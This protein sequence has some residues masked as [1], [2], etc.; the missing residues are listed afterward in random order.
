[1]DVY[2]IA[3]SHF[4]S[5]LM[6]LKVAAFVP[7]KGH[8][9]RVDN[10]NT[11]VLDGE[12]LFKRKLRQLLAC[13][14]IDEVWL[15]TE[16]DKLVQLS[17]DL[18]IKVLKRDPLLA[19]NA[20]DGHQLFANQASQTSAD[21]VV[22]ALC[23]SPFLGSQLIDDAIN[24]L[25]NS[26]THDSVVAVENRK[27]YSWSNGIPDYGDSKIPNSVDLPDLILESMSLYAVRRQG[28]EKLTKRFGKNPILYPLGPIEAI[29]VNTLEDLRLAE[30]VCA[31]RRAQRIGHLNA[32]KPFLSSALLSDITKELGLHAMLSERI[33]LQTRGSAIGYGKTLKLKALPHDKKH[34]SKK[35]WKGIFN[36]LDSY[37]FIR[38]GDIILVSTDVPNKAYFGDLNATIA[39]RNGAHAAVIDGVTRD[40]QRVSDMGMPVFAHSSYGDDIRFEGDV[41]SMNMPIT[42]GGIEARNNDIVFGDNDGVIVVQAEIWPEIEHRALEVIKKENQ[43]KLQAAL[44][45]DPRAILNQFG[46][47]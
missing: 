17:N 18:P 20:T 37:E 7:A 8:S 1:M 28:S 29:D 40:T 43:I 45:E 22:Q 21:I 25:K 16:S 36:A 6:N 11:R 24:A 44:G 31:G 47:F 10:K 15:D 34:P 33:K 42:I 14:S 19:T 38:P 39:L 13:E 4:Q 46:D 41:E 5:T 26:S 32:I 35:H 9:E 27:A 12:Y 2:E 23:T 30:Q 3:S